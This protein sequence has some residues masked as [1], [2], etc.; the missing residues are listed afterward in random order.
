MTRRG[1]ALMAAL[2]L[3]VA[4]STVSLELSVIARER[5]LSAI[6]ILESARAEAAAESGIEHARARLARMIAQGGAGETWNDPVS[7]L[8]PWH[9]AAAVIHDSVTM[10]DGAAYRTT[11]ADLGA[12]LNVNRVTEDELRAF[13]TAKA[14]DAVTV[15]GLAEAII[16]WRDDDD[17][18]RLHGAE[19]DDYIKTGVRELPRNGP[20]ESLDELRFVHG[21]NP[22]ILSRIRDDLSVFGAGQVNVNAA[23][24]PV[25]MSV[26]GISSVAA[27]II[28]QTQRAGRRIESVRQLTDLL[29]GQSRAAL[30]RALTLALPR[31][32]FDTHEVLVTSDGWIAGSPVRVREQAIIARGGNTAFVTWRQVE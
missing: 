6:N 14:I 12:K 17:F 25:L 32:T 3:V 23:G 30:E 31:L 1:F 22:A 19:R 11:V 21:M 15:D 28:L 16:D 26:S 20:F 7:V 5:R 24:L 8:D 18:R 27:E 13:L 2:W 4:I 29:P 10:I 9:G